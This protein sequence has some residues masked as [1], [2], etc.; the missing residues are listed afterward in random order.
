MDIAG[1]QKIKASQQRVFQGILNPEILQQC[2]PGCQTAEYVDLP[3]GRQIKILIS[4]NFPGFKG[5]YTIYLQPTEVVAPSH[6]VLQA[7]PSSSIGSIK[8]LCKIDLAEEGAFTNLVYNASTVLEGK[9]ANTPEFIIKTAV[10]G[11]MDHFFKNF[12]KLIGTTQA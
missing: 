9:I 7:A 8:T 5:P 2:L 4:P 11:A 1:H 12:E 6:I 10:K 3:E